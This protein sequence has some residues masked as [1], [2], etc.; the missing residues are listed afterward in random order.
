MID[1]GISPIYIL[2]HYTWAFLKANVPGWTEADY[3]GEIPIIAVS[4]EPEMTQYSKP[5]II[6]GY[7]LSPSNNL[8]QEK[9]GSMTFVIRSQNNNSINEIMNLLVAAFERRD[10]AAASVNRFSTKITPFIGIR[11]GTISVGWGEGATPETEEGGRMS[12]MLNIRFSYF[13]EYNLNYEP[14]APTV[15]TI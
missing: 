2:R 12:G 3:D 7:A 1:T 4:E 15:P 10:D 13:A 11:F 9:E 14:P 8:Y 6:Y 5:L